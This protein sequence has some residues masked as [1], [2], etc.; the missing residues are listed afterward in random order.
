MH[1]L[2]AAYIA[3]AELAAKEVTEAFTTALTTLSDV[4]SLRPEA[5][6][7]HAFELRCILVWLESPY[8]L[9]VARDNTPLLVRFLAAILALPTPLYTTLLQRLRMHSSDFFSNCFFMFD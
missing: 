9:A 6:A 1:D 3:L 5:A 8:L 7:G 2:R 4:L